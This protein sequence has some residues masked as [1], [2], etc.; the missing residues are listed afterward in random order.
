MC[1]RLCG[2]RLY[3]W[4]RLSARGM[5]GSGEG[6]GGR[7]GG[8][9]PHRDRRVVYAEGVPIGEQRGGVALIGEGDLGDS[10]GRARGALQKIAL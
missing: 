9:R 6:S 7:P 2:V 8:A 3:V 10:G 5:G 1:V 4:V